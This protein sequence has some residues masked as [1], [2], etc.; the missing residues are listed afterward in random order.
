MDS[1]KLSKVISSVQMSEYSL[2]IENIEIQFSNYGFMIE[3]IH[4]KSYLYLRL[5]TWKILRTFKT[6][7]TC[8]IIVYL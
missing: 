3:E 5:S 6:Y 1:C 2:I 8:F 7:Y 4:L